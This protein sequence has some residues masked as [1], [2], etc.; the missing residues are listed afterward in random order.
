M[1]TC[2]KCGSKQFK[3]VV[4]LLISDVTSDENDPIANRTIDKERIITLACAKCG[5]KIVDSY[6]KKPIPKN[7]WK[8]HWADLLVNFIINFEMAL[9]IRED[10]EGDSEEAYLRG[11][12]K[13]MWAIYKHIESLMVQGNLVAGRE[14]TY[15]LNRLSELIVAEDHSLVR[16]QP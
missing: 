15:H 9:V 6:L 5:N 10:I 7:A 12:V 3:L 14:T 8:E 16:P 1:Q 11:I 2:K 4:D 13:G